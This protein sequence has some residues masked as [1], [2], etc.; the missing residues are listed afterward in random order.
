MARLALAAPLLFV[1]LPALAQSAAT[2]PVAPRPTASRHADTPGFASADSL[3][4]DQLARRLARLYERQATLLDASAD[5]D[6]GRYATLLD[7]LVSDLQLLGQRPGVMFDARFRE[8]YSAVLTEYERFYDTPA[9]DRGDVYAFREAGIDA[10]ERGFD[11]GVPLLE[12]VT[13]PDRQTFA[14][15]IPMDVNTQVERYIQFLVRRPSHVERL[16]SRSETYLPMI[17]RVLAEEGVPDELKYLAMVESALNPAA[18][19]H[20]AAAGMWQF[21]R[22]TGAAYGLQATR[23]VD[24][25][26]DPERATRAAARHLRDLHDRFG[27]WQLALAGYN[28]NPAVIARAAARFEERTGRRATFWDIEEAIPRETRA[29]VPMFIATSLVVSNPSAYGISP[30][31]DPGPAYTFDRMP[32]EAGTSLGAIANALDVSEAA[33]RALNPSLRNGRVPSGRGPQTVRIPVGMYAN[34]AQ[35]L[36]RFA[37]ESATGLYAAAETVSFGSRAIRPIAPQERGEA[38]R[39]AATREALRPSRQPLG[40]PVRRDDPVDQ[41]AAAAPP[42]VAEFEREQA[43]DAGRAEALAVAA[44]Q[45]RQETPQADQETL[46]REALIAARAAMVAEQTGEPVE[47]P[48]VTEPEV[49]EAAEPVFVA[50]APAPRPVPRAETPAP[51]PSRPAT[52]VATAGL[53]GPDVSALAQARPT[54]AP[55]AAAPAPRPTR[56]REARVPVRVVS[57]RAERRPTSHVVARGEYLS[58]IARQY[59]VTVQQLRDWNGVQGDQLFAGRRLIVS[60]DAAPARS[61]RS[62]P[63]AAPAPAAPRTYTVRSGDNLTRIAQRAGVSVRDLQQWNGLRDGNVRAGQTLRLQRPT[64]G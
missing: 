8:A 18:Q 28:C 56:E 47:E 50:Q 46:D 48:E 13:L 1:T 42:E 54:P 23:D 10:V 40:Q 61:R 6:Q 36:A 45:T 39:V 3:S 63:A 32:V 31:D 4:D 30:T 52:P 26:L 33:I 59:G 38:L 35:D 55:V 5:G 58:S 64:R 2:D 49:T 43:R 17:E 53:L 15:A 11:M 22:A 24:D 25:R 57:D 14:T 21:I 9:L 27:D 37:P 7:D 41:Y 34:H 29:Y 12:H 19:S 20:M 51:R 16:L 44:A 60:A 62:T